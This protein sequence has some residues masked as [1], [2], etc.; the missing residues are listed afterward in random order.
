MLKHARA[1]YICIKCFNEYQYQDKHKC[2]R[3]LD[4]EREYR[5]V[6]ALDIKKCSR[7]RVILKNGDVGNRTCSKCKLQL[8]KQ[9]GLKKNTKSKSN[10]KNERS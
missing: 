8:K 7:C 3:C 4:Y 2:K 6:Q 1:E 9:Y 10:D 5:K